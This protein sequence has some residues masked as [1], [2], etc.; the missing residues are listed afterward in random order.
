MMRGM[1]GLA[2][3]PVPSLVP[4]L[5]ALLSSLL[6]VLG[7][8]WTEGMHRALQRAKHNRVMQDLWRVQALPFCGL[9]RARVQHDQ[10]ST[11]VAMR[12]V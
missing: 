4:P 8:V 11:M 5:L 2:V 12:L 6:R 10:D 1:V 7:P 3:G 9:H